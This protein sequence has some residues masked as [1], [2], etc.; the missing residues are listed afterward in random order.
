V[1]ENSILIN[2]EAP[3]YMPD[4]RKVSCLAGLW[5]PGN[6]RPQTPTSPSLSLLERA[7]HFFLLLP[8]GQLLWDLLSL[9][10]A[11]VFCYGKEELLTSSSFCL[12]SYKILRQENPRI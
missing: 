10:G 1:V 8:L 5:C 2:L 11:Q 4:M 3:P 7:L 6:T 9:L 12:L